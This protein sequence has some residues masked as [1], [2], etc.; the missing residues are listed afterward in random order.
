MK[1]SARNPNNSP[2]K[3]RYELQKE[4]RQAEITITKAKAEAEARQVK[5]NALR[6][7]PELIELEKIKK[8]NGKLPVYQMG[9]NQS[10]L[11][12]VK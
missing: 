3:K 4:Q 9:D 2:L 10:T 7:S 11:L 5:A 12:Q 8:W 1:S 6:N